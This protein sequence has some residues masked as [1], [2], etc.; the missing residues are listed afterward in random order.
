MAREY[1][2]E[3]V[4]VVATAQASAGP[5]ATWAGDITSIPSARIAA[6][7]AFEMAGIS[8]SDLDMAEVHDCFTIAEIIGIEDIGLF[9]PGKGAFAVA[10]GQTSREAPCTVNV[11][12][13]LKSKGH[14]VGATGA[15]QVLEMWLQLTERAGDR[16]LKDKDLRLGLTHNV[17]GTGGTCAVHIMERR[18]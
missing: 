14:P 7:Q 15:G 17:G 10:E 6:R 2:D 13:G 3:V 4:S 8:P 5:L 11:S 9:E 16:Q 12:G 1:T 18:S